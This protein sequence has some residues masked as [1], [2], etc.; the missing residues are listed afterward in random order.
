MTMYELSDLQA[1]AALIAA[2]GRGVD[3][4]VLL[5][6]AVH[7]RE[8]NAAAL[9]QL[10]SAGADVRWPP[11]AVIYRQISVSIDNSETAVGTGNLVSK[12]YSG[13]RDGT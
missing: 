1:T 13:S 3:T 8:T 11:A 7:G 12:Y 9:D 10:G 4:K 6:A 5:G 2:H